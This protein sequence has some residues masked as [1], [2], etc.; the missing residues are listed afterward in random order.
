MRGFGQYQRH[1]DAGLD[2]M[3]QELPQGTVAYAHGFEDG[4]DSS[5]DRSIQFL[6]SRH[7]KSHG[8]RIKPEQ[9]RLASHH[10]SVS[11]NSSCHSHGGRAIVASRASGEFLA[12]GQSRQYGTK[13]RQTTALSAPHSP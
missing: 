9:G 1:K 4:V 13:A 11:R 8:I 12:N 6:N 7:S 5:L 10:R 2:F 3:D